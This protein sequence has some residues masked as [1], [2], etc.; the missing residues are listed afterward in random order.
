[1][2]HLALNV[3]Y[4]DDRTMSTDK[5]YLLPPKIS[6]VDLLF[7]GNWSVSLQNEARLNEDMTNMYD[8]VIK[9]YAHH[10][11]TDRFGL[12]FGYKHINR[13]AEFKETDPWAELVFPCTH[14]LWH[15]SHHAR[16]ETILSS[17]LPGILPR[18][19]YLYN[20]SR[21]LGD[22]SVYA[23]GFG[24]IRFNLDEKGTGPVSGFEQVRVT[25]NLGFHLGAYT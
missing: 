3:G 15:T 17:D 18:V 9:L 10:I 22:S 1:M 14:G 2:W 16:F 13:P 8:N 25:A 21:Q 5:M 23:T 20:W 6:W 7:F 4:S 12:S 24:A 11:F 19:R